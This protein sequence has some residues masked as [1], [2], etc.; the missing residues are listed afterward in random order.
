ML[1]LISRRVLFEP[2]STNCAST[3]MSEAANRQA[4]KT[5]NLIASLSH[6]LR[7]HN[8]LPLQ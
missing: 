8:Q 1:I 3:V 2:Q 4:A 7:K 6:A 5:A